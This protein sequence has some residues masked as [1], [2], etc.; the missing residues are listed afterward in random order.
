[1][2]QRVEAVYEKGMLRPLAPL[3][4]PESQRVTLLITSS[5]EG[6]GIDLDL[7]ERAKFE[8][9]A[10]AHRP[11]IEEVRRALSKIPGSMVPDVVA[12]REDL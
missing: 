2:N 12:E 5:P 7:I 9:A 3:R 11:S 4:L 10:M 1:M 8:V 6:G